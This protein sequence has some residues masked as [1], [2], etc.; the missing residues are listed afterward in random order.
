MSSRAAGWLLLA[1]A[2][3]AVTGV[4]ALARSNG[5]ADGLLVTVAVLGVVVATVLVL[6]DERRRRLGRAEPR[7]SAGVLS[8]PHR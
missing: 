4:G 3:A 6:L 2:L 8:R 7:P 1:W 5:G